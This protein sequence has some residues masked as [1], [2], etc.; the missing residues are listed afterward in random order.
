MAIF[1]GLA[2]AWVWFSPKQGVAEE[3][4]KY[5]GTDTCLKCHKNV[6]TNWAMSVHR[7]T[8]FNTDPS[9][10]GC[11]GCH[12]AGSA[13]VDGAG[14]PDKIVRLNKLTPSAAA[15]VCMSCHTQ[16]HV[17]LW[18]TS[19][20]ARAKLT[21]MN[22]HDTHGP[23]PAVLTKDIA[24]AKLHLEGLTRS[25]KDAELTSGIASVD[26]KDKAEANAR[27]VELRTK[28][29]ALLKDIKGNQTIFER[30][31]EPYVCYNCHK[32]Q[33]AQ[34]NLPSHHPIK[35]GKMRCSDCHNPHGGPSGMLRG[36]SINETCFRCHAEKLGPF[37]Y[38]H[39][40]VTEDCMIC[41]KPHGSV[42]NNMLAQPESFLCMKCHPSPHGGQRLNTTTGTFTL[43]AERAGKCG[44]CHAETHG[45]DTHRRFMD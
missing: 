34:G 32:T 40:P 11:E 31:T 1:I 16:D 36:E 15:T 2:L 12:G 42:N 35:E 39:P 30:T 5:V 24:N 9:K 4:S 25:I 7:R 44:S 3:P 41:H 26:S 22:C 23:D 6:A 28:R 13:H 17:T 20:H 19:T 29:D 38:D 8:L 43:F 10:K 14:D 37:V 18:R 27:A 33:Q 45:S 21:C